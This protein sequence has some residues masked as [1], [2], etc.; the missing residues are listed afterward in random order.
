[1]KGRSRHRRASALGTDRRTFSPEQTRVPVSPVLTSGAV[2]TGSLHRSRSLQVQDQQHSCHHVVVAAS[3]DEILHRGDTSRAPENS[4][5]RS[6]SHKCHS[7]KGK[8]P[9]AQ[10]VSPFRIICIPTTTCSRIPQDHHPDDDGRLQKNSKFTDTTCSLV[11]T[12]QCR[13]DL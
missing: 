11:H 6:W 8:N 3:H 13:H 7:A 10:V 9:R 2:S 1:M 5:Q 4:T 12:C